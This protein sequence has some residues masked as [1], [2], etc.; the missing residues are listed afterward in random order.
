MPHRLNKA[1][2]KL[3]QT[4]PL[5]PPHSPHS[6][7]F[8]Q[9]LAHS[10][11]AQHQTLSSQL[12]IFVCEHNAVGCRTSS[13]NLAAKFLCVKVFKDK[14]HMIQTQHDCV[15]GAGLR[16]LR[17]TEF[18]VES[19]GSTGS[20]LCFAWTS[21]NVA[22]LLCFTVLGPLRETVSRFLDLLLYLSGGKHA[23]H[24]RW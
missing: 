19:G 21:C 12:F 17:W 23:G 1:D 5:W 9:L 16:V 22:A 2:G 24:P 14:R 6:P 8:T 4:P 15:C 11:S 7:T 3:S 20:Q 13:W 10:I 18:S